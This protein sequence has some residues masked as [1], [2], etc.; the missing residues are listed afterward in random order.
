[1]KYIKIILAILIIVSGVF[2]FK[3]L[4]THKVREVKKPVKILPPIVKVIPLEK[5]NIR[6][7]ITA[8]GTVVPIHESLIQPEV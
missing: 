7:E 6:I 3:Y 4:K 2:T 1:M 5:K 8:T